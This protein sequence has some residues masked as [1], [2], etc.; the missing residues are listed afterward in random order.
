M[1]DLSQMCSFVMM[2]INSFLDN[3]LDET[4]ADEVRH[5]ISNCDECL[6]EIEIW[7]RIRSAVK[8]AY[9]PVL[10]PESLIDKITDRIHKMEQSPT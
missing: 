4:T 2:R 10:A 1:T 3:E 9:V 6:S 8:Q 7:T 5:H